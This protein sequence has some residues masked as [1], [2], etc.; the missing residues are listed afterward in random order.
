MAGGDNGTG[1]NGSIYWK[2]THYDQNQRPRKIKVKIGPNHNNDEVDLDGNDAL[3]RDADTA[4][5]DA[6]ARLGKT[7]FPN[8]GYFRV[9]LRY[10]SREEARQA[11]DWVAANVVEEAGAFYLTVRVPAINR[12]QP[13]QDLPFEVMVE[14]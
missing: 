6:G 3:G 8:K 1:G 2:A 14:W 4:V 12:R 5:T 7:P 13:R 11:G 9:R 10:G